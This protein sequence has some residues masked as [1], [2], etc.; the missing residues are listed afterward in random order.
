ME[1]RLEGVEALGGGKDSC[2]EVEMKG[3]LRY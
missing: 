1:V 3:D 2:E